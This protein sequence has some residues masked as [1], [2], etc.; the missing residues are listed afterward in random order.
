M[1]ILDVIN[2]T[3]PFFEKQRI[4]SP[5]LNIELL[6]A[7]LLKKKRLD[8]Y[9]EFERELDDATLEK[10]REM[11]RRRAG[12]EPV[13]YITGETE[14]CGLKF[15]VDKRVLI[16]RPETELLVETVL[17]R[18]KAEGT[19]HR[20]PV[21]DRRSPLT[22][23]DVGTGS[24]CIA[25]ALA[26]KLLA[27]G[28]DVRARFFATDE[29]AEA[30]AVARANAKTHEVEKNIGFFQGDM[31]EALSNSLRADV[32]VSNPP[33]V[34]DG[35]LAKLPKEV[36]DFEPVRALAAGEDGLKAIRRLVMNAKR[37]MS[38]S[39]F[40]ALEIGAGQRPAVEQLFENNG[41]VVTEV[42]KDL[43]GHERVIVA[44]PKKQES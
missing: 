14:F 33:Y 36:R 10:L 21:S 5:R 7:H 40:V 18:L 28:G 20:L 22:I 27:P 24:G 13:Q 8:L 35:E 15:M 9:L 41:C 43:Q 39:G 29:S 12:G 23:L 17:E 1:R 2:K 3:T 31:L 44:V 34:A 32:I 16:P 6:L 37:F 30:L 11:V 25:I 42:V 19:S 38:P 26:K 4:E